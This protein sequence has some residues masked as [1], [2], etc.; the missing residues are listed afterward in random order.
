MTNTIKLQT[1]QRSDGSCLDPFIIEKDGF[2]GRQDMWRGEPLRLHGFS[3]MGGTVIDV[4]YDEFLE[5]PHSVIFLYPIFEHANGK[6]YTHK[7]R[8]ARVIQESGTESNIKENVRTLINDFENESGSFKIETQE[9]L[10]I[11][12]FIRSLKENLESY[13]QA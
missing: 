1:A 7:D 5:N 6:W 13:E 10:V 9:M 3:E 2:V 12:E 11:D 8:V 4:T